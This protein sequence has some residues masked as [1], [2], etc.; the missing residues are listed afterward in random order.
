MT[1]TTVKSNITYLDDRRK[2]LHI[3]F[4]ELKERE[5][6]VKMRARL[7]YDGN[8]YFVYTSYELKGHGITD[9]TKPSDTEQRYRVTLK[10]FE[11]LEKQFPISERMLL[12]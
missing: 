10:A 8:Y 2:G 7:S 11:K 4:P 12:D 9:L 6:D 5:P 3:Y 1:A